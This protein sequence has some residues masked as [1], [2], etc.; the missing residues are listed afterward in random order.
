MIKLF[1]SL[2]GCQEDIPTLTISAKDKDGNTIANGSTTKGPKI[3]VTFEF[4]LPE[5]KDLNESDIVNDSSVTGDV[6]GNPGLKIEPGTFKRKPENPDEATQSVYTATLYPYDAANTTLVLGGPLNCSIEIKKYSKKFEWKVENGCNSA[7][8]AWWTDYLNV[9]VGNE[10]LGRI[11]NVEFF[12]AVMLERLKWRRQWAWQRLGRG[13]RKELTTLII[14]LYVF[15]YVAVFRGV[16]TKRGD[17]GSLAWGSTSVSAK[18]LT[19]LDERVD[20]VRGYMMLSRQGIS[21]S[22]TQTLSHVN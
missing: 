11:V 13:N 7:C 20:V 15:T 6:G 10:L 2:N 9:P 12:H 22:D 19:I 17:C 21:H 3:Y 8:D 5:V 4:D 18:L 14:Y 16:G 1:N